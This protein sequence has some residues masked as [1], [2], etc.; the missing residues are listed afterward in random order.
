MRRCRRPMGMGH[1]RACGAGAR[2]DTHRQLG[3][4]AGQGAG[5]AV[6]GQAD[7]GQPGPASHGLGGPSHRIACVLPTADRVL[8]AHCT[9]AGSARR[10]RSTSSGLRFS[11]H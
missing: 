3:V 4:V 5:A 7:P 1:G 10:L 9:T 6:R 2:T 8:H 11:F